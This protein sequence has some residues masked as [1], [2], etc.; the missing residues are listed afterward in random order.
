MR[1]PV[2]LD[3]VQAILADYRDGIPVREIGRRHDVSYQTVCNYAGLA[4]LRRQPRKPP[5]DDIRL[6]GGRWVFDPFRRV[7]VWAPWMDEGRAA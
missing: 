6:D 3:V 7:Q 2:A 4:G 5:R 1:T